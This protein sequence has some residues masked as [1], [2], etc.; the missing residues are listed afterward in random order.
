[1]YEE[2]EVAKLIGNSAITADQGRRSDVVS[3]V[4]KR[5]CLVKTCEGLS[6]RRGLCQRHYQ[7]FLR[8]VVSKPLS[9]RVAFEVEAIRRGL[10]LPCQQCRAIRNPN[11]FEDAEQ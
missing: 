8:T 5:R 6:T 11:P 1:M 3:R 7:L 4:R 10:I 9:D 2:C